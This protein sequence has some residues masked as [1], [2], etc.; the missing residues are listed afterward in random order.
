MVLEP[1]DLGLVTDSVLEVDDQRALPTVGLID[2][3]FRQGLEETGMGFD[4]EVEMIRGSR[5][6]EKLFCNL[7]TKRKLLVSLTS[8]VTAEPPTGGRGGRA[9]SE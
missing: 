2:G 5:L 8:T 6:N 3:S 9:S 7:R 4:L 1:H